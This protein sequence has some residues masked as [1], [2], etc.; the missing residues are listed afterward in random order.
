MT[1]PHD[2]V[3][4]NGSYLPKAQAALPIEDR[5]TLF[6]DGVYEV[7]RYI[8]GKAFE[9][10]R[11]AARLRRSLDGIG[12]TGVDVD[13]IAEASDEVVQRNALDDAAVYWQVTR[14]AGP[15]SHV[16]APGLSPSVLVLAYPYK[17]F[18]PDAPMPRLAVRTAEDNRWG[19]CWIKTTMLLPNSRAKT[20]AQRDGFDD[21]VFVRDGLV[22]EATSSN[23]IIVRGGA[24]WTHPADR[25]ILG[26]ITRA[27]VL[28]L[29][30]EAGV[31]V[32]EQPFDV[33][34]MISA[35]EVLLTGTTTDVS[36]VVSVD[37]RAIADGGP[38]PVTR[39]LR[40]GLMGRMGGGSG[41]RQGSGVSDV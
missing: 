13:A 35:E 8:R 27:V 23:L 16:I 11:H 7:T 4:L 14:G 18:D 36:A 2:I 17:P 12:V 40:A 29:A 10:P 6:G 30:T 26:G 5:G 32:H 37:G 9:K 38:G 39:R 28:E 15:R 41:R 21:A 24:L 3:Y 33:E 20:L 22:T 25:R 31:A 19:D 34:A 1:D